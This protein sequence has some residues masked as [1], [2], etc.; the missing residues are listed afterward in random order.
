M[1]F[2]VGIL[3]E[4]RPSTNSITYMELDSEPSLQNC[5]TISTE[6]VRGSFS[7]GH[8]KVDKVKI[9][10]VVFQQLFLVENWCGMYQGI[11]CDGARLKFSF[12]WLRSSKRKKK[13]TFLK[14]DHRVYRCRFPISTGCGLHQDASSWYWETCLV[15][16]LL[17]L[18]VIEDR[19]LPYFRN[20][21]V[22]F[23]SL[24]FNWNDW[25]F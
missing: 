9:I 5:W 16:I 22:H 17:H 14:C 21:K 15:V 3:Q 4:R 10:E 1:H 6:F 24:H 2:H 25:V 12:R 18:T 19:S 11:I 8:F 20:L 7:Y 13:S 23:H